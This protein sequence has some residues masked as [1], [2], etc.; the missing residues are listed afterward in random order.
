VPLTNA[1]GFDAVLWGE[2]VGVM[3]EIKGSVG[4]CK[5][6]TAFCNIWARR[7]RTIFPK[8]WEDEKF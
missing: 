2:E 1:P 8:G 6:S 4:G 3:G 5:G 7:S